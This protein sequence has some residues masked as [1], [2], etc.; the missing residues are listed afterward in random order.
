MHGGTVKKKSL[1]SFHICPQ[2]QICILCTN[3]TINLLKY[4]LVP[5]DKIVFRVV[6]VYR[7]AFL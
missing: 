1:F 5:N 6:F 3:H 2:K 4:A 7:V